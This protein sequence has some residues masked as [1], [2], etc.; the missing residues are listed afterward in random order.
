M[1]DLNWLTLVLGLVLPMLTGLVTARLAHAGLKAAVLAVLSAVGGI[2]NE[3]Y[4]VGGVLAGFDW[5]AALAN[6]VSVFLIGVGLHYGLLAPTGVTGKNGTLQTGAL[7]GGLGARGPAVAAP[8]SET[9]GGR[10]T[11]APPDRL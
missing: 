10:H 5:S 11:D 6:A 2:G 9:P 1:L 8:G 3:L 7:E 4:S